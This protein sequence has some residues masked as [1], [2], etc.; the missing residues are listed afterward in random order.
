MTSTDSLKGV[1]EIQGMLDNSV[2]YIV[3]S[4]LIK[5]VHNRIRRQASA[6]TKAPVREIYTGVWRLVNDD[7]KNKFNGKVRF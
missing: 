1:H 5:K 7:L 2:H 6:R 3:G 4:E